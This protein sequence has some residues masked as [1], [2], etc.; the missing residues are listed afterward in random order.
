MEWDIR[1]SGITQA[2]LGV[3]EF[4]GILENLRLENRRCCE[5]PIKIFAVA[6]IGS[7]FEARDG[8]CQ[9]DEP[10][11]TVEFQDGIKRDIAS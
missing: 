7:R 3:P 5:R 1:G 8:W 2:S 11:L 6:P 4:P 10:N 9:A